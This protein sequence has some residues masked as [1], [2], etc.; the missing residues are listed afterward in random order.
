[1]TLKIKILLILTIIFSLYTAVEY[2]IQRFVVYPN[3][4]L[5]ENEEARRNI[6][7]CV[8]ALDRE[9]AYL[10]MIAS[11]LAAS[12]DIGKF[13]KDGKKEYLVE[14][15]LPPHCKGEHVDF[16]SIYDENDNL[17][18]LKVHNPELYNE[19]QI[20]KFVKGYLEGV[21]GAVRRKRD[22]IL[23]ADER[24]ILV[25]SKPIIKTVKNAEVYGTVVLGKFVTDAF[26]E[27]LAELA[28]V[29][30]RFSVVAGGNLTPH[31]TD[32]L[33]R[34]TKRSEVYINQLGANLLQ[35]YTVFEN[36]DGQPGLLIRAHATK[37]F[38]AKGAQSMNATLLVMFV[39][40]LST[41]LVS[42]ILLQFV[43]IAPINKLIKHFIAIGRNEDTSA[44]LSMSRRDEI[45]TLARE[46][47]HMVERLDE[48]RKKLLEK[49]YLSGMAEMSS[50]VLHNARN[51]LSPILTCIDRLRQQFKEMPVKKLEMAQAELESRDVSVQRREDLNQ[52]I[53]LAN[54]S[55]INVLHETQ[56]NLEDL[57]H[58]VSQM[59]NMLAGQKTFREVER[60]IENVELSKLF[61]DA[62][63]LIPSDLRKQVH[64]ELDESLRAM[65]PIMVHRVALLQVFQNIL[66]NG[67]ESLSQCKPLYAKVEIKA[68]FE[69]VEGVE[70]AH[71]QIVD[72]GE[73]IMPDKLN[74]IFERGVSSKQKGLTGIGLHWCANTISAMGGRIWVESK[75]E[76]C[77]ACF[78]IILPMLCQTIDSLVTEG[79]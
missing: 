59:E 34:I 6:K 71:I 2:S 66:I 79:R 31:E 16:V 61:E 20:K 5:L 36:V 17:F 77:G 10:A 40:G 47:D 39:A 18:W 22:G 54:T 15:L 29:D 8:E 3:F 13:M 50:A 25:A 45:G 55:I 70:V 62:I 26:A 78:H 65:R 57:G 58:Q 43:I 4:V 28:G 48:A 33:S 64:I 63:N 68:D 35:L 60:P 44:R 53:N 41:V 11:E 46:F 12:D 23:N 69:K 38:S 73:G 74:K 24:A 51:S 67:A 49:S 27:R 75:G 37:D 1:M 72:N 21:K 14:K 56:A 30:F 7:H 76:K 19:S 52:F 9:R 32:V 42:V